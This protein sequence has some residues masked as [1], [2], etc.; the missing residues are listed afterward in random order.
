MKLEPVCSPFVPQRVL[1]RLAFD[2]NDLHGTQ[3]QPE[4][5]TVHG[6]M[7]SA[8]EDANLLA[9]EPEV[10][11]HG[12]LDAGVSA[13][14]HPVAV[15]VDASLETVA[16]TVAGSTERLLPWA[17]ACVHEGHDPRPATR[18]RTYRS[19]LPRVGDEAASRV[20][21]TWETFQGRHDF[22]EFARVDR[23][24]GQDPRRV[25]ASTRLWRR[26]EGL[27]LEATAPSFLRHQV[28]RMV[29]ACR[30]VARGELSRDRVEAAL[31]GG[32]LGT[33]ETA[34]PQGLVLYRVALSAPWQRLPEA[35]RAG[36]DTLADR[37]DA[38]RRRG[39]TLASVLGDEA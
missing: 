27:V 34:P 24:R 26:G 35:R 30:T 17:G 12:R 21:A 39:F 16:A 6:R 9:P 29:G 22:S 13:R 36:A 14:D 2:G 7:L 8:L 11:A 38:V 33:Y 37:L 3:R 19:F 5:A 15:N 1:L 10:R 20:R 18:S 31:A 4:A 28:R 23:D 25:V 32:S